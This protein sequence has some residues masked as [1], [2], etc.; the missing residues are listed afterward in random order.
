VA[1]PVTSSPVKLVDESTEDFIGGHLTRQEDAGKPRFGRSLTLPAGVALPMAS[2]PIK[3]VDQLTEDFIRGHLTRQEDAGSPTRSLALQKTGFKD[4][5]GVW[6][7]KT[8][9]R[10]LSQY[11]IHHLG[12]PAAVW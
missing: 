9:F 7:C 6:K 2:S 1:L 11:L 4:L 5:G 10:E 8:V 12:N 3:L